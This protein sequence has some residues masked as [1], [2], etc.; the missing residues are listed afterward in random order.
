MSS[1]TPFSQRTPHWRPRHYT[2]QLH[3]GRV[4][5][6]MRGVARSQLE[7]QLQAYRTLRAAGTLALFHKLGP[8]VEGKRP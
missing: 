8:A 6:S 5:L 2:V 3:A 4:S 7:A 1:D